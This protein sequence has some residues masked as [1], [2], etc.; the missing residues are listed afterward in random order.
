MAGLNAWWVSGFMGV[1]GT[2][3]LCVAGVSVGFG[4]VRVRVFVV[5]VGGFGGFFFCRLPL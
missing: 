5:W 4:G 3:I 1:N 2:E